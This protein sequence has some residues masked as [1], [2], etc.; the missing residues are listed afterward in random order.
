MPA[1]SRAHQLHP[2]LCRAARCLLPER[3]L[4]SLPG[5]GASDTKLGVGYVFVGHE[6]NERSLI[7][8]LF[9]ARHSTAHDGRRLSRCYRCAGLPPL[10]SPCRSPPRRARRLP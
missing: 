1:T 7:N 10:S 2:L 9:L 6:S 4:P 3:C 8:M 5:R